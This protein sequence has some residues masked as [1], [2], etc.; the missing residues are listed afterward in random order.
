[1]SSH[2][3]S[4]VVTGVSSG[5]G[6]ATAHVLAVNGF[7]VFGTVRKKH[8][9]RALQTEFPDHFVPLVCDVT[10][11]ASV[12][13]AAD[14]V[15]KILGDAPLS[16]LVNNAGIALGGPLLCLPTETFRKQLDVNLTGVLITT[17]AFAPLLGAKSGFQGTPGRI[18]NMGSVGGRHAFPFMGPYHT[19][20]FGIEGFNESLRRELMLFGVDVILVAP[21][22]VNTPIW[23]KTKQQPYEQYDDTPYGPTMAVF[24]KITL[25]T[26]RH[27]IP[28]SRVGQVV[29][30]ALTAR[31][32][33]TYYRV[34]N[35]PIQF[36]M[37]TKLPKRWVDKVIAKRL[38]PRP[39]S[40]AA[41][42]NQS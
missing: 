16:G 12:Q 33:H 6:A 22:S 23:E 5:I 28:A 29:L 10:D 37:L 35:S 15:R 4:V 13:L 32:P 18:V 21:G 11:E 38:T 14:Q 24:A 34:T 41:R 42:R 27:G 2:S 40:S 39:G 8:D 20:K 25:A 19:S 3:G 36:H 9:A 1:M 31:R 7:R 17:K 26:G 30:T